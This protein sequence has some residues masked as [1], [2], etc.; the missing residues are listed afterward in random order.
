MNRISLLYSYTLYNLSKENTIVTG[1]PELTVEYG[2][3][4]SLGGFAAAE[5]IAPL[6]ANAD[7]EKLTDTLK[8][9]Y[10]NS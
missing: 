8:I 6:S 4:N 9:M 3:S 7:M 1:A 10:V 5:C 2:N